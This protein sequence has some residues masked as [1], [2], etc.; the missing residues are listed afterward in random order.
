MRRGPNWNVR[1][2]NK[3]ATD[4]ASNPQQNAQMWKIRRRIERNAKAETARRPLEPGT[5]FIGALSHGK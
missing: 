3:L 1:K 2:A 4:P 5:R